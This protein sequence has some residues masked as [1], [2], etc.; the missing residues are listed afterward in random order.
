M[1]AVVI[2]A[3]ML[4]SAAFFQLGSSSQK[5]LSSGVDDER[6]FFLAEAGLQE[7]ITA[8]RGGGTGSV[9]NINT[10]AFLGDGL[11]WSQATPL[12]N[13]R[14]SVVVTA[15][16]GS[17]RKAIEA[18]VDNGSPQ[19]PLFEATLLSKDTLTV[20]EDVV[21]DSYDSTLGSYASQATNSTNG[22][23]HANTDGDVR[24]NK[25]VIINARGKV[26]GDATPGPGY[27]VAFNTDSYVHGST[28]PAADPFPFPAV[29]VPS[30]P[31]A[32]SFTVPANG[33]H[34]FAPGDYGF[35]TLRIDNSATLTV[36]GPA[37]LV[38]Q[39][40]EG[41]K[42]A[43]LV[44][45]ATNGPVTIF[46]STSY[47]HDNGFEAVAAPGSPMALAFMLESTQP[48][49]FPAKC[50]V[51][52]AYYAPN[53]DITFTSNN[54]AWGSFAGNRVS[55]SSGMKFHYDEALGSYWDANNG[56]NGWS[57][58]ILAWS[59]T[60]VQPDFLQKDRRDPCLVLGVSA[61]NLPSPHQA[62]DL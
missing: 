13:D 43:R 4:I 17:G 34:T 7:A 32:G 44:I 2:T 14:T 56:Q 46:C 15:L 42:N 1:V 54:E 8:I 55:M 27:A 18:V 61:S 25:D 6:A 28:T 19:A 29:V 38:L 58:G 22:I 53:A 57:G 33:F 35:D 48:V 12:A 16:A 52:G 9:G 31:S 49:S 47:F 41:I 50:K 37:R 23:V 26:F 24:S 3:L 51:R 10:P 5:R 36:Q 45:D 40:F 59:E 62:W 21:I 20:N 60:E 39:G 11:F 30:V